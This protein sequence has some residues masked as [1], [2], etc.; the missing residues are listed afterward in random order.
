MQTY[1]CEQCDQ[2]YSVPD[3]VA[4]V[5]TDAPCPSCG[6]KLSKVILTAWTKSFVECMESHLSD[7]NHTHDKDEENL[8]CDFCKRLKEFSKCEVVQSLVKS[9]ALQVVDSGGLATSALM[10]MCIQVGEA[11]QA[12]AQMDNSAMG[13]GWDEVS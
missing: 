8:T 5:V 11:M 7:V 6:G 2:H 1:R 10:L 13:K 4:E 9:H 12:A 3:F